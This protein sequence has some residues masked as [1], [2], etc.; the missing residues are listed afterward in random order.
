ML[1]EFLR[2]L[3]DEG[4]VEVMVRVRPHAP[5]S[6]FVDV[7]EDKSI[8]LD[9][10]APADEGRG[11]AALSKLL[12]ELFGVPAAN[13]KILSGKTARLK[14]VRISAVRSNAPNDNK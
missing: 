4:R 5:Q 6:K 13:V 1:E 2:R 3:A 8:K 11:N 9:I 10:A 12:G 7:L 14:L